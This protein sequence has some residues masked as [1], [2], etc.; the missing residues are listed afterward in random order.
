MWVSNSCSHVCL[1]VCLCVC[2]GYNFWTSE[3]KNDVTSKRSFRFTSNDVLVAD[4]SVSVVRAVGALTQL[5]NLRRRSYHRRNQQGQRQH[6]HRRGGRR[7]AAGE[8]RQGHGKYRGTYLGW[9]LY[10]AV[11]SLPSR[12]EA[13]GMVSTGEPTLG[14]HSIGQSNPYPMRREARGMV[15]TG[16]P[17]LGNHSIG[18][19][20]PYPWEER[21][22]AW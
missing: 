17:T 13:R 16:E 20:N 9:S 12:R 5:H 21:Q 15:S 3:A 19:L 7:P 10:W 8:E 22:G 14:G 4:R 18:Q 6:L 1:S 2:S 11:K